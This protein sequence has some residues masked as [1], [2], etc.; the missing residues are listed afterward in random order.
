MS[1][2][3][4]SES[5][6]LTIEGGGEEIDKLLEVVESYKESSMVHL[7]LKRSEYFLGFDDDDEDDCKHIFLNADVIRYGLRLK[8]MDPKALV[9]QFLDTIKNN[10]VILFEVPQLNE[11]TFLMKVQ[12]L[13]K[14][15][16]V[17]SFIQEK[18]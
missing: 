14:R 4:S 2:R 16:K 1:K 15:A 3:G 5:I 18:V 17:G 13:L 8:M 12:A 6:E 7:V 11:V 10:Q 9:K